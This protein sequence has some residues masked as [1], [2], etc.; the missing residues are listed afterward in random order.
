MIKY[1]VFDF[2][3]TL[4]DSKALVV[5]LFNEL[6][7]KHGYKKIES[8]NLDYIRSLSII[9]R[10]RFLGVPLYKIPFF[11]ARFLSQYKKSCGS[12]LLYD[13]IKELLEQLQKNGYQLAVL[14]TNSESN[15]RT[16][17][18]THQIHS[19]TEF[20]CSSDLFGKGKMIKKFLEKHRLKSSEIIYIGDEYRDMT[21]CRENNVKG[22]WVS[23]G[24]DLQKKDTDYQLDYIAHSPE[25]LIHILQSET[26]HKPY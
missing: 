15:I 3:G 4:A 24:Y 6:A 12:I 8:S 2:D 16:I 1:V 9:E 23:W 7:Q 25:E 14:S 26:M 20:Y 22:I 5:S 18:S 17:L 21:A 11:S 19:I 10:C 13:G